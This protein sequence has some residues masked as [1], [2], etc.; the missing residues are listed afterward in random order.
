M[1]VFSYDFHIIP[2]PARFTFIVYSIKACKY[3]K[4]KLHAAKNKQTY[5]LPVFPQFVPVSPPNAAGTL[6]GYIQKM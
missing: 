1:T 6:P 2:K 5:T 4:L 3:F